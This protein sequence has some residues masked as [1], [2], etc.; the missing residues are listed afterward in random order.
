MV[1]IRGVPRLIKSE[2]ALKYCKTFRDQCPTLDELIEGDVVAHIEIHYASRRA[3][4]DESIILDEMQ[5]RIYKNDRQVKEKHVYWR[6]DRD[7]PR[8]NIRIEVMENSD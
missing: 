8:S 5:G 3:D 7:N 1:M 6:L 4:L 2:K